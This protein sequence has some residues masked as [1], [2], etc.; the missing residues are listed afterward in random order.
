MTG[1]AD[2]ESQA[3][4]WVARRDRSDWSAQDEA[5]LEDW[6]KSSTAHRV[7]YLRLDGAWRR[8]D[9]L[10]ALRAPGMPARPTVTTKPVFGIVARVAAALLVTLLVGGTLFAWLSQTPGRIY[11][12]GLGEHR[13]VRLADGSSVDLNTGTTVR[14]QIAGDRRA[15]WLESGE[16]Y[17]SVAHDAQ[18]PFVIHAG[19]RTVTVLGTKFS[20]RSDGNRFD[21]LVESG[22]VQVSTGA[23]RA[24][25]TAG[26]ALNLDSGGLALVHETPDEVGRMLSWRRGLL[27]FGQSRLAEVVQEFNRYNRLQL[28]LAD[29]KSGNIRI[30]GSFQASNV[31]S[32]VRLLKNGFGVKIAQKGETI[33]ISD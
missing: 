6:L 2:I 18:H 9:R 12:S 20:V 29:A 10:G 33:V 1:A 11:A 7:A 13:T 22:R 19:D 23:G 21:V 5:D 31:A 24:V 27:V 14:A 25:L 16:A 17:F 32:F 30:G 4:G 26:D 3:A 8:A 15:V 28:V